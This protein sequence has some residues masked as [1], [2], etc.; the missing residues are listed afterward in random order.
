[1][2]TSNKLILSALLLAGAMNTAQAAVTSEFTCVAQAWGALRS[3]GSALQTFQK[4]LKG[5]SSAD[6]HITTFQGLAYDHN[7]PGDY[8]LLDM[9]DDSGFSIVGRFVA[10]K[11][12]NAGTYTIAKAILFHWPAYNV[13]IHRGDE[14]LILINGIPTTLTNKNTLKI[15]DVGYI[16]RDGDTYFVANTVSD[17]AT[18]VYAN[19]YYLDIEVTIPA[20]ADSLGL[21]GDPKFVQLLGSN[22]DELTTTSS[23]ADPELSQVNRADFVSFIDSWRITDGTAFSADNLPEIPDYNAKIY[24]LADLNPEQIAAAKQQCD[25]FAQVFPDSFNQHNCLYDLGFGGMAFVSSVRHYQAYK[26]RLQVLD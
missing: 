19:N 13:E 25:I 8:A 23:V 24:S 2:K 5:G 7:F 18:V 4:C 26:Q 10:D 16:I 21:L 1:M 3:G 17:I 20:Q 12:N 6:P 9:Q 15:G 14:A 22:G 11:G